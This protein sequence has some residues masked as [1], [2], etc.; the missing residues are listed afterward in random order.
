[1]QLTELNFII[2]CFQLIIKLCIYS[3]LLP[4]ITIYISNFAKQQTTCSMQSPIIILTKTFLVSY[5]TILPF[6]NIRSTG[7]FSFKVDI[8]LACIK[9]SSINLVSLPLSTNKWVFISTMLVLK[10]KCLLLKIKC[11]LLILSTLFLIV[12]DENFIILPTFLLIS[13]FEYFYLQF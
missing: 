13:F 8:L 7:F 9:N 10:I 4:K 1:M 6:L 5:Q 2:Y 3:H 12:Q 11:L